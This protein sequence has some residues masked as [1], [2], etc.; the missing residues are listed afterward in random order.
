VIVGMVN[1]VFVHWMLYQIEKIRQAQ[2]LSRRSQ[3]T[4]YC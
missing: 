1:L 3:G 4:N 2:V